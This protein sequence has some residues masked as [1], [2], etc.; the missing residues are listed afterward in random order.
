MRRRKPSASI[1]IAAIALFF[2]LGGGAFAATQYRITSIHQVAP[3]VRHQ[4]RGNTGP[5]GEPGQQGPEGAAGDTGPQGEPGTQGDIGPAAQ[6]H[7]DRDART[8]MVDPQTVGNISLSCPDGEHIITGGA[9][10]ADTTI[11][12]V[13]LVSSEPAGGTAW[14][15]SLDNTTNTAISITISVVCGALN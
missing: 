8:G 14:Q 2:S 3:N 10:P 9:G 5:Q 6:I 13:Y 15:A 4:L 12:G 11:A 1:I 7:I